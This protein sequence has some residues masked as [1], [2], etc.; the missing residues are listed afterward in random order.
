MKPIIQPHCNSFFRDLQSHFLRFSFLHKILML[1]CQRKGSL[2]N[3]KE[4][5]NFF[6]SEVERVCLDEISKIFL[7]AGFSWRKMQT[8]VT[9]KSFH[10]KLRTTAPVGKAELRRSKGMPAGLA[11]FL[12]CCLDTQY[13]E[14]GKGWLG[15]SYTGH[16]NS[17]V[18]PQANFL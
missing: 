3:V 12:W 15:L 8:V 11:Y 4:N 5:L 9:S 14:S 6:L 1:L 18:G 10:C 13:C 16:L 7:T 17:S 2:G